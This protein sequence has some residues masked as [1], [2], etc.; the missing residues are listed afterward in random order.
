[1]TTSLLTQKSLEL[2]INSVDDARSVVFNMFQI[3]K[4]A[5][6][7]GLDSIQF[8]IA[9][10]IRGPVD[11]IIRGVFK[12]KTFTQSVIPQTGNVFYPI[13][14]FKVAPQKIVIKNEAQPRSI[15]IP[16]QQ[17]T[18][19][20]LTPPKNRGGRPKGSKN[21]KAEATAQAVT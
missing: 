11:A 14:H 8:L 4:E 19:P 1:M 7:K 5:Q 13:P 10:E 18:A 6:E 17:P 3:Q 16:I 15:P 20:V 9:K 12:M 2:R 21:K